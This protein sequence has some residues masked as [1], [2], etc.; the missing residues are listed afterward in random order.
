MASAVRFDSANQLIYLADATV[1]KLLVFNNNLE[2]VANFDVPS[3]VSDIRFSGDTSEPGRRN[4]LLTHIGNMAP[5][6]AREGSVIKGWY[7]PDTGEGDFSSVIIDNI[8]RPVETILADLDQDGREDLLISEFGHRRGSLFWLK[9]DGGSYQTEKKVL[10]DTPGC[11]QSHVMDFTK[12]GHPD[13]LALCSQTDQAVYLFKNN[14][15]GEFKRETLLQFPVAAGSSS[16]ELVDFNGDGNLDILYTSGDNADY[17]ITYKP[18]HGVYIY[19]NDGNDQFT[20]EWFY[21]VNGAY[22]V[23]AHDFNGDGFLDLAVT[24]FFADYARK[25]QEGFIYFENNGELSFT[26]YHPQA[27]SYGRWIAMDI[28]DWSGNGMPDIV[29]AN[30]S[31]GPTKVL[32]QIEAV[33]TQ[34]PHLLVL[35]N[36]SVEAVNK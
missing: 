36:H 33:L 6:D 21:P 9:N 7:N 35:E 2:I 27:A 17:S 20:E 25:P 14:G 23:K 16:F 3:P 10:I 22:N 34:S 4:L 13:V 30:F 5:S 18:Y 8:R 1:E 26:P 31:R 29:L 28:D 24:S 32:P 11:L 15:E 12:N 19:L